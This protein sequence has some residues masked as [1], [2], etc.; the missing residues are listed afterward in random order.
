MDSE[1]RCRDCGLLKSLSEFGRNKSMK[2]GHQRYCKACG[3]AYY[4]ANKDTVFAPARA[5][6]SAKYH[7]QDP[8]CRRNSHLMER[9]KLSPE[10]YAEMLS[11][12]KNACAICGQNPTHRLF[13]DHDHKCCSDRDYTCGKCVRG[14]LCNVC[15]LVL[16]LV[17]DDI[18]RFES[19]I[20]Y[21][22]G[23]ET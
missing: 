3:R 23:E 19:F 21:L 11:R 10:R 14:L 6:A 12:Q 8:D 2:D 20:K 17:K 5:R 16:G 4:Q 1:K 18:S 9:Y 15:N 22:R 13:V 7:A